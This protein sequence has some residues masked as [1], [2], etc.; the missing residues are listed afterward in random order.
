MFAA[1]V[2]TGLVGLAQAGNAA[3]PTDAIAESART[4]GFIGD[5]VA[6][7]GLAA[8]GA[9]LVV[10]FVQKNPP[11]IKASSV[12]PWIAGTSAGVSVRF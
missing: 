5:V 1:G 9:G 8:A 11:S 6:G 2:I 7:A 4:K 12:R 10:L 3:S